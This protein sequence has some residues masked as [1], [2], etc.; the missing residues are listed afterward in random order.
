LPTS[1]AV[2]DRSGVTGWAPEIGSGIEARCTN[3]PANHQP[4]G[5]PAFVVIPIEEWRRIEATLEDRI[6]IAAVRD[7]LKSPRETFPDSVA[8]AILGGASPL[9]ALREHRGMTQAALAKAARTNPV[10]VSQ[11]ERGERRAGRRLA[12]RLAAALGVDAALL[13]T[14]RAPPPCWPLEGE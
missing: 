9:K 10:Y 13:L 11:I 8:G 5:K 12:T 3:E 14:D 2:R 1:Q 7:F 6:D 4:G